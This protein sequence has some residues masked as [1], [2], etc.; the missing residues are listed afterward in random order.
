MKKDDQN[1]FRY[2]PKV[3]QNHLNSEFFLAKIKSVFK[4]VRFWSWGG[5]VF[6]SFRY[7]Y[8]S[9]QF[10]ILFSSY[11]YRTLTTC[12]WRKQALNSNE[13]RQFYSSF[14]SF[15]QS[16]ASQKRMNWAIK[17]KSLGSKHCRRHFTRKSIAGGDW[18]PT[19][20]RV[21]NGVGGRGVGCTGTDKIDRVGTFNRRNQSKNTMTSS[22]TSPLPVSWTP[23][24]R[25]CSFFTRPPLIAFKMAS[26][27]GPVGSFSWINCKDEESVVFP[28][29]FLSLANSKFQRQKFEIVKKKCGFIDFWSVIGTGTRRKNQ[30]NC[31]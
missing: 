24:S 5:G 3:W 16:I 30:R 20:Y 4:I 7:R 1:G 25:H 8:I 15:Q 23:R 2:P 18:L 28:C 26:S 14:L 6:L 12:Y 9:K 13:N 31:F 29:V 27:C 19:R 11:R 22:T 17:H 10:L 21:G